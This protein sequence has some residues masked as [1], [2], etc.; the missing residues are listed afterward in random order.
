MQGRSDVIGNGGGIDDMV[1][2][3]LDNYDRNAIEVPYDP[4]DNVVG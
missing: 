1:A 4:Y 2:V 3:K